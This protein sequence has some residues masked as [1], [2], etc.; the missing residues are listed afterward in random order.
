MS[1]EQEAV[2]AGDSQACLY[3]LTNTLNPLTFT[4]ATVK[5][6]WG[7]RIC[8]EGWQN[9]QELL[10]AQPEREEERE[11]ESNFVPNPFLLQSICI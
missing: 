8:D 7:Q 3:W 11:G 5:F 1:N 2:T 10:S 9:E 4:V 6:I